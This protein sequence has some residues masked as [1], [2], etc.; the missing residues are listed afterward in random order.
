MK[1][2]ANNECLLETARLVLRPLRLD[3]APVIAKLAGRREIADTTTSIPHPYSEEQ[4]RAWIAGHI[5]TKDTSKEI[6]FAIILK[7]NERL[8]G[9]VG[10]REI[11]KEHSRAEMG[12]WVA[13]EEWGER[14][15]D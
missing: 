1:M 10:L 9:T 5:G 14:L 2:G 13:V 7:M 8:I 6:I 15:C 4:A 11:D 12:Y 3:D